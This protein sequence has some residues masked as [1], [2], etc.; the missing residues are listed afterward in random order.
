MSTPL[1]APIHSNRQDV[2][3]TRTTTATYIKGIAVYSDSKTSS[4][5]L[6]SKRA[7]EG[8]LPF[9]VP[10][11]ASSSLREPAQTLR[12]PAASPCECTDESPSA[13][14]PSRLP[15]GTA[16]RHWQSNF[17]AIP[18][19][20]RPRSAL[21]LRSALPRWTTSTLPP[22]SPSRRA[23]GS[24]PYSA[25][26]PTD[27][28]DPMGRSNNDPTRHGRSTDEPR[29]NRSH[30]AHVHASGRMPSREHCEE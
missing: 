25:T 24:T 13:W 28:P 18:P 27:A 21:P 22:P 17:S 16:A 30:S 9:V 29:S 6:A 12:Y 3:H 20:L 2:P 1:S 8:A 19:N 5:C 23:P 11:A 7:L 26:L 14:I 4:F 10:A 15:L